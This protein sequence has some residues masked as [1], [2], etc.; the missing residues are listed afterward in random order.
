MICEIWCESMLGEEDMVISMPLVCMYAAQLRLPRE[1]HLQTETKLHVVAQL[2]LRRVCQ[3][4]HAKGT[5]DG[6]LSE[7]CLS[8]PPVSLCRRSAYSICVTA[9]HMGALGY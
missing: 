6:D 5:D 9:Q 7:A 1:S 2:Y 3:D 4:R 8:P